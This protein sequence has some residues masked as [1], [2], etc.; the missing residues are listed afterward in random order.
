M[1]KLAMEKLAMEK[2]TMKKLPMKKLPMQS[3][4]SFTMHGM[5]VH[6]HRFQW[7]HY[8]FFTGV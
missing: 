6:F 2:L 5:H 8:R 7:L 1:G 4:C 3:L